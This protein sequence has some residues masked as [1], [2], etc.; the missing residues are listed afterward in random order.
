MSYNLSMNIH[1]LLKIRNLTGYSLAK[2]S[3]VSY[4]TIKEL[5]NGK[6]KI[7]NLPGKTILALS[8]CLECS[9]EEILNMDT[10]PRSY[11]EYY[12]KKSDYYTELLKNKKNVVLAKDSA[13]E[14][15][16]LSNDA[17]CDSTF[18][19]SSGKLNEPYIS[20]VVDNFENIDYKI[21]DGI[22]VTTLDQTIN[23]ILRDDN[24]NL[25]PLY[26]ALNK[27]Y[28]THNNSFEGIR[29]DEDNFEKFEQVSKESLQYYDE[30]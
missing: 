16:H 24:A 9:M 8:Q 14:F 21:L 25:Q 20:E 3:G 11:L 28:Y 6:R 10:K 23:D 26:E 29:I 7:E 19:Y 18:V 1:D 17:V 15:Y 22:M 27:Y 5:L 12:D 13:L 30:D 2:N 4:T